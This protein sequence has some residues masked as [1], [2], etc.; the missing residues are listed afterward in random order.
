MAAH[1]CNLSTREAEARDHE[2][3]ARPSQ[4]PTNKQK[5][6][7][8]SNIHKYMYTK[9]LKDFYEKFSSIFIFMV[10]FT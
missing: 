3:I 7:T 2:H 6:T 10:Y 5:I 8:F 9:N 4:K 1:T